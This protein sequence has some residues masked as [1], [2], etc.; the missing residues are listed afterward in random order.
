[1]PMAIISTTFLP[2]RVRQLASLALKLVH[3]LSYSHLSRK[4]QQEPKC[5]KRNDDG[6]AGQAAARGGPLP[7]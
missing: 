4:S 1:M 6:H 3:L 7:L 5:R 2:F